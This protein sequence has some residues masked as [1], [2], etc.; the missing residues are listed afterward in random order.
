MKRVD[1]NSLCFNGR[2]VVCLLG[3]G[4]RFHNHWRVSTFV[5]IHAFASWL[6]VSVS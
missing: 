1:D 5:Y 4:A 6:Y 3:F 2:E